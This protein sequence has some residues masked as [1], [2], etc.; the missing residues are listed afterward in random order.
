VFT[1]HGGYSSPQAFVD[2]L[3]PAMWVGAAVLAAGA[4]VAALL[5]FRTDAEAALQVG[6]LDSERGPSE[7]RSRGRSAGKLALPARAEA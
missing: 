7:Q 1:S 4:A 2:G 6:A 3:T 5:P